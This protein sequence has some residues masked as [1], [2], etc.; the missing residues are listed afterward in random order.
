MNAPSQAPKIY[1]WPDVGQPGPSQ[2]VSNVQKSKPAG[3]FRMSQNVQ[4]ICRGVFLDIRNVQKCTKMSRGIFFDISNVQNVPPGHLKCPIRSIFLI[5][6]FLGN[7]GAVCCVL[8]TYVTFGRV[9]EDFEVKNQDF[10][11]WEGISAESEV[12]WST[13][14]RLVVDFWSTLGRLGN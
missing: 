14:G 11:L 2:L 8:F 9:I 13:F 10:Q 12:C 7:P 3:T 1:E 6:K 5:R 4:Q